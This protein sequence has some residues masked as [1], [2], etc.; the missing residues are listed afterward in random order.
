LQNLIVI[1]NLL[2]D[3]LLLG[4]IEVLRFFVDSE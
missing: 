4:L 1:L 2:K 3:P